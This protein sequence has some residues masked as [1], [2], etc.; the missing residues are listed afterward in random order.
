[1]SVMQE[2]CGRPSWQIMEVNFEW[3]SKRHRNP[4]Q[5]DHTRFVSVLASTLWL[6]VSYVELLWLSRSAVVR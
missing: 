5:D 2:K 3:L 1:M 4:A 6:P